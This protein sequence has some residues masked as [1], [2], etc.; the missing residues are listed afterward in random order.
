MRLMI[1]L[2]PLLQTFPNMDRLI[3]VSE[4]FA[5]SSGTVPIDI[6]RGLVLLLVHRTKGKYLL[7]RG[8]KNFREALE[9]AATRQT[10]EASGFNCS[11]LK[12]GLITYG[13]GF[14]G[15]KHREPIAVL[16][17]MDA[18]CRRITFWYV[19]EVD[20]CS[21]RTNC[22]QEGGEDYDV[23]WVSTVD[24]PSQCFTTMT[25]RFEAFE[26]FLENVNES[27]FGRCPS[28]CFVGKNPV[29]SSDKGY[30]HGSDG[31][32]WRPFCPK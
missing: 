18:G 17:C 5:F 8:R 27:P 7:P 26:I 9:T 22:T 6:P 16:Q 10:T 2:E 20:S 14:D 13:E 29:S 4:D 32:A 28:S 12:H 19:S 11:L 24:A 1:L 23:E 15:S 25:G 3:N 21:Q 30:R 31:D